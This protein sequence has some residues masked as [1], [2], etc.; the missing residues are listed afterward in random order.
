LA[1]K[2]IAE[3]LFNSLAHQKNGKDIRLLLKEIRT[4]LQGKDDGLEPKQLIIFNESDLYSKSI[5]TSQVT[6]NAKAIRK[7]LR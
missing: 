1:S 7:P 6:N 3:N 4:H 5:P 2:E